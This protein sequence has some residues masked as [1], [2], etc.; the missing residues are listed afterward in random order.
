MNY[1]RNVLR[2]TKRISIGGAS[3]DLDLHVL[4]LRAHPVE[5][6]EFMCAVLDRVS[7]SVAA[8]D[9]VLEDI[10][11]VESGAIAT[12]GRGLDEYAVDFTKDGAVFWFEHAPDGQQAGGRVS[13]GQLKL[14][15]QTFRQFLNDPDRK[16]I[17]VAFPDA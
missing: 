3:V 7:A 5:R 10:E 4:S 9:A 16:V 6:F 13:L 14:A 8:C 11:K 15:V 17:E 12:A 2:C 1:P